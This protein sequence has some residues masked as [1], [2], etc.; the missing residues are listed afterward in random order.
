MSLPVLV[1]SIL[2]IDLALARNDL[3]AVLSKFS[4][5]KT[6]G[7]SNRLRI[8][9]LHVKIGPPLKAL[10]P[11]PQKAVRKKKGESEDEEEE[12]GEEES[13]G[14]GGTRKVKDVK[15]RDMEWFMVED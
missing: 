9:P 4:G 6:T 7:M 12:D 15:G 10:P 5:T 8:A 2:I 3:P 11:V 1:H 13:D 14:E